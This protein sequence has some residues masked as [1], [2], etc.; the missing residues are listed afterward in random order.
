MCGGVGEC[1]SQDRWRM[2]VQLSLKT[3]EIE[4]ERL[5][6]LPDPHISVKN[7]LKSLLNYHA[8]PKMS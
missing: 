4:T 8:S 1:V 2:V 3:L 7:V 5:G 6:F